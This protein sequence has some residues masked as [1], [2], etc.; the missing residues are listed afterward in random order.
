VEQKRGR[1]RAHAGAEIGHEACGPFSST[2][3]RPARRRDGPANMTSSGTKLERHGALPAIR[4]RC[5]GK[6]R[7]G[8]RFERRR[9]RRSSTS[10]CRWS[11]CVIRGLFPRRARARSGRS[12]AIGMGPEVAVSGDLQARSQRTGRSVSFPGARDIQDGRR[13]PCGA[14]RSPGVAP[15]TELW[16]GRRFER[17]QSAV[18]P[19]SE[20]GSPRGEQRLRPPLES[21]AGRYLQ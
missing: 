17:Q 7:C 15:T 20:T 13:T 19:R 6:N 10:R 16:R 4:R 12:D 5:G 9:E 3:P 1:T 14:P 2:S 11:C 21:D 18:R 8:F